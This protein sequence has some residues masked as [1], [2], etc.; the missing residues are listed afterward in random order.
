MTK[1]IE[2]GVERVNYVISAFRFFC[3]DDGMITQTGGGQLKHARTV[4]LYCTVQYNPLT[5]HQ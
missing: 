2:D 3:F 4:L 1:S 5:A